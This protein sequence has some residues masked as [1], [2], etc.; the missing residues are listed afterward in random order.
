MNNIIDSTTHRYM[1]LEVLVRRLW[2]KLYTTKLLTNLKLG[3]FNRMLGKLQK[4]PCSTPG[5]PTP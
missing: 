1:G 3:A 4:C 2:P 5:N